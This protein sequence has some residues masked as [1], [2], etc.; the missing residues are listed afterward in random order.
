MPNYFTQDFHDF[1][2][3]LAA[4][5]H[6]DWMDLNKKR[7]TKS[8]KEAFEN[9]VEA[10]ILELS[11]FD[12]ELSLKASDAIFRINRDI[13][14]SADK[15]PYKTNRT[16]LISKY[17]RKD[18]VY[19]GFYLFL[20]PEKC[21]VGGGVYFLEKE[22]LYKVR[23]EISYNL[24]EFQALI[25]E[26]NFKANFPE[27]LGEKGKVLPKEFQEDAKKQQ[28]L[29]NKGFYYMKDLSPNIIFEE[30]AVQQLAA[31]L[32]SAHKFNLFLRRALS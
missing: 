23:Q 1:F 4:N 31:I 32:K 6:K 3:E 22:N 18:K 9:F 28:L 7:Y 30:D 19:P 8:V 24:E 14:F 29:F 21:M 12:T 20:S 11:N 10:L 26:K 15:T 17:G 27:I 16:A 13:R 25:D 2:I 5:N